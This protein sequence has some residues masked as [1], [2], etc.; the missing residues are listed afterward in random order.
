MAMVEGSIEIDRPPREVFSFV[1][2]F[3]RYSEWQSAIVSV[4]KDHD[5]PLR[6]GSRARVIRL[7]GPRKVGGIDEI[8]EFDPPSSWTVRAVGGP[9]LAIA[10]G[11]IRPVSNGERSLLTTTL[12]FRGQG[13]GKLI[14]PLARRQARKQL[15]GNLRTLKHLIERPSD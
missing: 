8:T 4:R 9:L 1:T 13:V 15:P 10:R 12:D 3:S 14:A 7:V 5:G 11:T 2:D 6:L